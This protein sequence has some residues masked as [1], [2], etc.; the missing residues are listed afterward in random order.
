MDFQNSIKR[1]KR[2]LARNALHASSWF[3]V[4]LPYPAVRFF[5]RVFTALGFR[6]AVRQRKI[7][8]ESL[9]VAFGK[10]KTQADIQRITRE[11]FENLGRGMIEL[12]YF[13]AHP[14]M[15]KEKVF[16]EGKEHLDEAL[17]GKNGVI[18]VSAHFG[19]FPLML[20]RLAQ[21]GYK[22]NAIIRPARDEKIE[23]YFFG[24]RSKLGLNTIYSHPRKTCVDTSLK[25]LRNNEFLFIPLD[26]N[27]GSGAGVFV[28]FFGQK[29][30]TATGPV[31]FAMRTK[32]PILP[33]FTVRQNDTHKIL[34][35]PP[36]FLQEGKDDKETIFINTSRITQII[37]RYIRQYPEEWG[38]MHRRWKSRPAGGVPEETGQ[39]EAKIA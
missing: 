28:D 24:L 10:E 35:E 9:S 39:M 32:S 34:I 29:A 5:T 15:I 17:A 12:I 16:F 21:E 27:F 30:A 19:N 38:W 4:R 3:I 23:E 11:C 33:V 8:V 13:M 31:V 37:E 20:L 7:A 22:T 2:S 14:E 18:A 25:V 26:Q 36:I 1:F 6:L